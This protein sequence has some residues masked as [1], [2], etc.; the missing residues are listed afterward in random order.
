MT[1]KKILCHN[2]NFEEELEK[3]KNWNISKTEQKKVR[4]FFQKYRAGDIT[5]RVVENPERSLL[6]Y[7]YF[8]KIGLENIPIINV[9]S[10]Q[11]FK[12]KLL[13]DKITHKDGAYSFRSKKD[14]LQTLKRYFEWRCPNNPKILIPLK[15]NIK[16]K[17]NDFDILSQ[18]QIDKFIK[19]TEVLDKKFLISILA[20]CGCRAE[21]FHNLR[22]S[23]FE[24]PK[25]DK[26]FLKIRLREEF[27]KTEG[28]TIELYD[29]HSLKIAKEYI[30]QRIN[31]GMKPEEA[32]YLITYL[33]TRK[34]L[35]RNSKKILGVKVNYHKF[36]HSRA[37]QLASEMNRQQLCIYFGW[38]FSSNMPDKYIKRSGVDMQQISE[39]FGSS[40]VDELEVKI[41]GLEETIDRR[42]KEF[43]LV[44]EMNKLHAL[45]L[46]GKITKLQYKK[47]YGVLENK[48]KEW[49]VFE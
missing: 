15:V 21:E 14:I 36:R 33:S 47:N 49:G 30:N 26:Q 25:G 7:L 17:K 34:W 37:T 39:K 42:N 9:G 40:N 43:V 41:E 27:T 44:N 23:D 11:D 19:E 13:G 29:K 22:H 8:I 32:V 4:E 31:E 35:S 18:E 28:R 38:E 16:I 48:G 12:D 2:D 5:N 6:R 45:L 46:I 1:T 20:S 3:I 24:F 10:V